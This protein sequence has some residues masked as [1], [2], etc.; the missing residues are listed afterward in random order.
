M[1]DQANRAGGA[2]RFADVAVQKTLAVDLDL[3]TSY[4]Q[5]STYCH[6]L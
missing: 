4:D 3:I 1:A 6:A 2:E 5:I